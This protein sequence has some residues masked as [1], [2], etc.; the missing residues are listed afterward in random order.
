GEE[1][2][3]IDVV[4]GDGQHRAVGGQVAGDARPGPAG[5]G[6]LE[7]VRLE[8]GH[9]VIVE[10]GVDG[11]RVVL[12]GQNAANVGALGHAGELVDVPPGAAPGLRD[13]D[14][15]VVGAGVE[16]ALVLGRFRQ[17]HDVAVEGRGQV[18]GNRV[19]GP[20]LAHDGEL[21]A[22]ELPGQVAADGLPR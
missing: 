10:R 5:V 12:R 11:V 22:I 19:R 13:L 6:A 8:V 18:L 20:E 2:V 14:Q 16:K 9:L 21:V 3:G 15:A 7:Q 4:F 1:Q 17:G